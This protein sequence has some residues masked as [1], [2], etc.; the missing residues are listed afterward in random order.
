MTDKLI[1]N[2]CGQVV[3]ADNQTAKQDYVHIKKEWGYFSRKDGQT[4]QLVICEACYDKLITQVAL[5]VKI[6]DTKE[7]L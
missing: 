5:P 2:F 1:C 3:K 4:H 7:L 6:E